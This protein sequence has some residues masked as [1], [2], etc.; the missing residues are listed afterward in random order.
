LL[1]APA[2]VSARGV[3]RAPGW[4]TPTPRANA[5]LDA[6]VG[7]VLRIPLAAYTA[8]RCSRVGIRALALPPGA[9]L[10]THDGLFAHAVLT[11]RP[12]GN[13][14]GRSVIAVSAQKLKGVHLAVLR[15]WTVVVHGPNGKVTD[16]YAISN[17]NGASQW[18][19][20]LSPT[21][22]RKRPSKTAAVVGS[23]Q[24]ET[25]DGAPNLVDLLAGYRDRDGRMWVEVPLA[26]LPNG[27]TGWVPRGALGPANVIHTHLVIDQ[28]RL[29]ATL[30]RDGNQVFQA[31]IGV[32]APGSRTPD[33]SFYVREKLNGFNNPFYG[34]IA[35]GTNGRSATLTDW[36]GGGFIGIHG[37]NEP[38]LIPGTPSHGCIRLK[39][40]DI[41]ALAR[42]M[43]LGTPV[44]IE[45][46]S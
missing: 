8:G 40:D 12:A 33:G 3:C 35:F 42:L 23:L 21:L 37:T 14:I 22:V 19:Y 16:S 25:P 28:S 7:R 6:Q 29:T 10:R 46:G 30:Y 13:D 41:V 17:P 39:N 44:T 2:S 1:A 31:P 24:V 11:W 20:L 26:T 38:Q 32:G 4:H 9:L 34:P 45:G 27:R 43:P 5:R 36:P 15:T 18:A